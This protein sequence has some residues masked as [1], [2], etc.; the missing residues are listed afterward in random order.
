MID[1]FDLSQ[2]AD[3]A[4][5]ATRNTLQQAIASNEGRLRIISEL[6]QSCPGFKD[7]YGSEDCKQVMAAHPTL[8]QAILTAE[9]SAPAVQEE[10]L[11][12]LYSAT[13]DMARGKG[14]K[15]QQQTAPPSP[16]PLR[17][18]TISALTEQAIFKATQESK[19][20][21]LSSKNR[22]ALIQQLEESGV[23]DIEF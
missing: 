9:A 15:P 16:A 7:F 10:Y 17:S 1:D 12:D 13:W 18:E 2:I 21:D 8:A 4:A 3:V 22:R 6:E 11:P 5:Q 20:I 14:F 19:Q 23:A